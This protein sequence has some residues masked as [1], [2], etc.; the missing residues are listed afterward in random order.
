[1][2]APPTSPSRRI[3]DC[4][5]VSSSWLRPRWSL[6]F[7]EVDQD[8]VGGEERDDDRQG[9]ND[10]AQ[11]DDA[12]GNGAEMAEKARLR[13]TMEEPFWSPT[14]KE[15]EDDRRAGY[16]ED[17]DERGGDDKG[18]DLVF[19]HRRDACADGKERSRHQ[20][21]GDVAGENDAVVGV[22]EKIDRDPEREG[23]DQRDPGKAPC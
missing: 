18:D 22:P 5:E 1:M 11:I 20:P 9:I 13:H 16:G 23:Q 21:A 19:C 17:E 2:V 15:A 7:F 8:R 3:S 12:A 10:I 4:E 6:G 14:L